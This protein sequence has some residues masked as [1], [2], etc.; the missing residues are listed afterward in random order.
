M[1][2]EGAGA[3]LWYMLM[4]VPVHSH[5]HFFCNTH[6]PA[7]LTCTVNFTYVYKNAL[8]VTEFNAFCNGFEVAALFVNST[9]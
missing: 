2:G 9:T 5:G 6:S 4:A 8:L 7:I 1:E 3:P